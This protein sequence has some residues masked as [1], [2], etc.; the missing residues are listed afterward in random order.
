MVEPA[1]DE[2]YINYTD[3]SNYKYKFST[4]AESSIDLIKL[5]ELINKS[6]ENSNIRNKFTKV[7]KELYRHL[8]HDGI[9]FNY[10][11]NACLYISY[12]LHKVVQQEIKELYFPELY[13]ALRDFVIQYN[14]DRSNNNNNNTCINDMVYI[15]YDL[16]QEMYALYRVYDTYYDFIEYK[17]YPFHET[18]GKLQNLVNIYKDYINGHESKSKY[19]NNILKHLEESI[20]DTLQRYDL[21]CS[22]KN[23][24]LPQ[25]K[26]FNPPEEK[27]PKV[28]KPEEQLNSSSSVLIA[29][30]ELQQKLPEH[31]DSRTYPEETEIELP[32]EHSKAVVD[33]ERA[34]E[35]QIEQQTRRTE[36]TR[37]IEKTRELEGQRTSRFSFN[38]P[39][40]EQDRFSE[41]LKYPR[42]GFIGTPEYLGSTQTQSE[43][44]ILD[45]MKN[46]ISNVLGSVDPVPV[47]GVSGGM[48]ALFLLFRYTP[49]GNFFRGGRGRAHRIPRSF[50]GQ[51]LGGFPGYEDYDVGHIGVYLQKLPEHRDSRTYPEE[52]EIELPQEHSK[53]VV[54]QERAE[55]TQIEQ[56]TRRTE[57][58]RV[59]EKTRELEGQRTSR[60]SFNAPSPEQD[61]FSETLK[62]PR[63]GFIGTPEYLGSTQTQSEAGIL[64]QMKNSISNVLGSVDPVPV[65]GVSGG[66]GAL[67]LLFRYT[68]FNFS[69]LQLEHSLEEEEDAH[70]ESHVVSMDIFQ[71]HSQI[72][73]NMMVLGQ[74]DPV[75][76]VGVSGGM[77]ALFLLFRL[78]PSLEEDE[79]AYVEFLVVPMD[80]SQEN[81]QIFKIMKV[82]LV[83]WVL[84][85]YFLGILQL[86]PSLE[87]EEDAYIEFPVVSMDHSQ[88]DFL[89]MKNMKVDILD[90][91]Q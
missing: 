56:Q 1:K 53:A 54:D 40:P 76:V 50:N 28:Q 22:M 58:T 77:G 84:Y 63:L 29:S 11:P 62:Y 87:E 81:S 18:C 80:H 32:Q 86:E 7:F 68:L 26:L 49:F 10:S 91:V 55:E 59:I 73:T 33:Q 19:F 6:T 88:E 70:I 17:R 82:Y 61:R 38:A 8:K 79:D 64:D 9:F 12:I 16:F 52:T 13:Q 89:D 60:F 69:I 30:Q 74:V 4:V 5:E 51:F 2:A 23:I 65:V 14:R 75:P 42:L 37:V 83:G 21:Q 20:K 48:G 78:E 90:M 39:S 85:S 67:F 15:D 3:Y 27:Q 31:R 36:E 35:T 43:A 46:S 47:V 24:P 34:E 25:L 45:Q 41:T 71:E 72:I 57:E 44:G 66:M